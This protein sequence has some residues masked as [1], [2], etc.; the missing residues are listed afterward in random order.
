MTQLDLDESLSGSDDSDSEDDG[1]SAGRRDT[2][3]SALLRKS[4]TLQAEIEDG[5][6]RGKRTRGSGNAP[7]IWFTSPI[8]PTNT[9]LGIYRAIFTNEEQKNESTIA[10]IVK[11]K[12]LSP[13]PVPKLP[14]DVENGGAPLPEAYKGPHVFMCMIGGGHF[15][16]MVVSL[17]PKQTKSSALGPMSK[18]AVVL[19]HKT[20]HR[21]T[22][23]RKQGGAQSANDNSKGNAHSAGAGIRRYNE[24][25]LQDEVRKLLSEWKGMIDTAELLFVRATGTTNR[26]TLFGP[27]EDQV[28]RQND[29]RIRG[30]PFSTRRAT[31]KELMR[32]FIELT[33]LKVQS[34]DE[35][36][37]AAAAAAQEAAKQAAQ[38]KAKPAAEVVA[39][40]RSE[41]EET[42]LLHTSQLQALIRRSK[43]PGLLSYFK[44]NSLSPDFYFYPKD[45][46][47][48][49][50]ASTSLHL[51][52][53]L[54]SATLVSGLL[55]KGGAN[56]SLPNGD[57]RPAYDLAGDRPTRDAFRVARSTLGENSFK[58]DEAHIPAAM[59]AEEA[60]N[61]DQAEKQEE[62]AAEEARRK[63]ETER[64]KAEGPKVSDSGPLGKN[65]S[66]HR[67][68]ALGQQQKTAQEVREAEMKGLSPEMRMKLERERRARAAEERMRKMAGES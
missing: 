47:Q 61:R 13:K 58:W 42:A 50:H 64:L 36:A 48:N 28:M 38:A 52:A 62:K 4:A 6:E 17:E 46:Q 44:T 18:E 1:D 11:R 16:A 8:V 63:A 30:F 56:P 25:A 29:A 7:I 23:R 32:S 26:R 10:D 57:G 54:N 20:F 12:Q 39:P 9:Y 49:H 67:A 43:L 27:Y 40:K 68:A 65:A 19:A 22:T 31:Q 14:K 41:E 51:A 5:E 21:Y 15:A 37:I 59:T 34:V 24:A 53:S 35:A 2:T 33:R 3:L 60:S 55:V 66:K 45:S